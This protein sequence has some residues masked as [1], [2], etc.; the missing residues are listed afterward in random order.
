MIRRKWLI[1][2]CLII[3]AAACADK[4]ATGPVADTPENRKAAAQRYLKAMPPQDMLRNVIINMTSQLTPD[5]RK[6]FLKAENDKDLM[7]KAY[8]ISEKALVKHFTP[9]EL[10]AMTNFYGS[11]AGKSARPKFS[12]YMM[13]IMPQITRE[14]RKEIIRMQVEDKT[15]QSK[16]GAPKAAP[17]PA[18]STKPE[19]AKPQTPQPQPQQPQA[20]KPKRG[21]PQNK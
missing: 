10:N 20:E 8:D 13:E 1:A 16:A 3:L 19:P 21:Q 9:D 11:A 18:A 17:P 15:E 7:K 2:L 4:A 12:P 14:V 6:R 5:A